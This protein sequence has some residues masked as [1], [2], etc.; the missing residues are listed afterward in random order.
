MKDANL[1]EIP[2][3]YL[4]YTKPKQE[5]RAAENLRAWQIETFIPKYREVRYNQYTGARTWLTRPL[6]QR[7]VFARFAPNNIYHKIKFTRGIHSVVT[8]GD[9]PAL[10][11]DWVINAIKGRVMEDGYV[12]MSDDL[13]PGDEVMIT[14]GP[15]GRLTAIFERETG[16]EERVL[17]LLKAINYQAHIEINR[18]LLK[19]VS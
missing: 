4:I 6:F 14:K 15:F 10:V 9:A 3:W 11:D 5:E 12:K 18:N 17:I 16:N 7:Y 19:K 13:E 8:S 2:S 1:Q